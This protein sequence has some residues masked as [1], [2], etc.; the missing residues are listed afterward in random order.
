MTHQGFILHCLAKGTKSYV[1]IFNEVKI[2]MLHCDKSIAAMAF[3]K[4]LLLESKLHYSLIKT[5][6][7]TMAEVLRW[8]QKYINLKEELEAK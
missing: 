2:E 3:C 4:G 5:Q 1:K 7:D 8:V 6:S